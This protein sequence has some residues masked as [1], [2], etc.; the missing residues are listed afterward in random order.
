MLGIIKYQNV[1]AII[2]YQIIPSCFCFDVFLGFGL[3]TSQIDDIQISQG[4]SWQDKRIPWRQHLVMA[5]VQRVQPVMLCWE[6]QLWLL[7]SLVYIIYWLVVWNMA[8]IFPYIGNNHPNWLSYLSE[9]LK[10]PTRYNLSRNGRDLDD[11][12]LWRKIRRSCPLEKMFVPVSRSSCPC[13]AFELKDNYLTKY[14]PCN[15]FHVQ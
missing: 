15:F 9:E 2:K 13:S 14:Y 6:D 8:F 10:P 5:A 3:F 7:S 11:M 12:S 1:V 4:I